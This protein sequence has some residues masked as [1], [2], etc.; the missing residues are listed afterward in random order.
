[1]LHEY[2]V[3]LLDHVIRVGYTDVAPVPMDPSKR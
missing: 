3:Q 1:L 2:V